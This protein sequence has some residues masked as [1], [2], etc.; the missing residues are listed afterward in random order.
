MD[1]PAL[2]KP[3]MKALSSI[4]IALD[5]LAVG[6]QLFIDARKADTLFD[7]DG[8][9][10]ENNEAR[11]QLLEGCFY[12]FTFSDASYVLADIGEN[13]IIPHKRNP[14]TGTIAPN[15]F[16][17]TLS[18]PVLHSNQAVPIGKVD[19]EV[20]SIKANY[21]DDYRDMLEFITEKCTDLLLQANAPASHYFDVDYTRD[22]QTLYQKFAFIKSVIGTDEFAEAIHKIVTAPVT[23]WADTLEAKDVRQV[24][25]FSNAYVKELLKGG[26]QATLP[27]THALSSLGLRSVPKR[28]T[29]VR[30]TDS[31]DTPENRFVKHVL[32]TLL[33]FCTDIH[34]AA[35]IQGKLY[36]ESLAL[37]RKLEGFLHHSIFADIAR[38]TMLKLNSP[39]LQRKEGYREVLRTWLM[40]D[41]AA[42]L[43][44]TGGEDV[45]QG[46]KKDVAT[47][48]EYWLFFKLLDLFQSTFQLK[49]ADIGQLI[50]KTDNGLHLRIKQ[51]K[52]FPV[53]GIYDA[54]SRKLA[55]RFSYNRSFGGYKSY[56][57]AGSWTRPMRPDYTLSFWPAGITEQEAEAQEL[58]VHI[59][60]DAKYKIDRLNALLDDT[61]EDVLGKEKKEQSKGI[62]KNADV[63]KMH[64]Y[65]DAIRRTGGAYVLYPGSKSLSRQGF[66]EII[67]GLGAFPVRPSKM[68]DGIGELKAFILAV[69]THFI[70]RSSQREKLA[71]HTFDIFKDRPNTDDTLHEALPEP[72]GDNRDLLPDD[73]F[74]LIGYYKSEEHLAWITQNRLYNFRAGNGVGALVLSKETVGARYLLLHT[75]GQQYSG[76]LWKIVGNGPQVFS[77]QDLLAKGYPKPGQD[78]YLV[79]KLEPVQEAEFANLQWDF[80]RLRNYPSRRAAAFPFTASLAELM[81]VIHSIF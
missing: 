42:K 70:N 77:K 10:L 53:E 29:A 60:F 72:Y 18:I 54:G 46:G 37:I 41:V 32:E 1:L 27:D 47:L 63:L 76:Q 44:W 69:L 8:S 65:K 71:Y 15:I 66:H 59:H 17:G 14:H 48:Y 73:S 33:Q 21:R 19:L 52:H 79:M 58:I 64:T 16:V 51:G 81:R 35:G 49:A 78:Y 62:Y 20:Q 55:I 25:R 9:A 75:K 50:E 36:H 12:D 4:T 40:F 43:I 34:R 80:K 57:D 31:V 22:S 11:Y 45:Y 13:I 23:C 3:N 7:G 6:L 67:P 2:P 68:D 38:P 26:H 56:P 74:V 24:R 5:H 39:I 61:S 30:K 28:I